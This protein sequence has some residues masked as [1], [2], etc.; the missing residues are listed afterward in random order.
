MS[1][2]IELACSS[3]VLVKICSLMTG[4]WVRCLDLLF[5]PFFRVSYRSSPILLLLDRSIPLPP[6]MFVCRCL[7]QGPCEGRF[8]LLLQH[9]FKDEGKF[10][11]FCACYGSFLLCA[12]LHRLFRRS[13]LFDIIAW[14]S[15]LVND[16]DISSS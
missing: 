4:I 9:T 1:A 11:V 6:W 2:P 15:L 5:F 16:V 7:L 8:A 12:I 14:T 3:I 13:R 10:D